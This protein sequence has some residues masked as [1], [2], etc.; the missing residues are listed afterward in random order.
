MTTVNQAQPA[1]PVSNETIRELM[2]PA[3][4]PMN[5]EEVE[6]RRHTAEILLGRPFPKL[7]REALGKQK[8]HDLTAAREWGL[9]DTLRRGTAP[10]VAKL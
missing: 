2:A 8:I 7:S 1:Q 3:A 9:L 10:H 5:T 6:A 4:W